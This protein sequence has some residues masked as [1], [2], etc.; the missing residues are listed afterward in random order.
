MIVT[1]INKSNDVISAIARCTECIGL[2]EVL[3]N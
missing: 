1:T 2:F 3:T